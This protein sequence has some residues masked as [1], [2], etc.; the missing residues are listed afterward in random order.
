MATTTNPFNYLSALL[1]PAAF[2]GQNTANFWKTNPEAFMPT[3][4]GPVQPAVDPMAAFFQGQQGA[5][6]QQGENQLANL[7]AIGELQAQEQGRKD[8]NN[9]A[10][11]NQLRGPGGSVT[12]WSSGYF[13]PE[14]LANPQLEAAWAQTPEWAKQSS[15]LTP[16]G[17]KNAVAVSQVQNPTQ[18]PQQAN[19]N[20]SPITENGQ[21]VGNGVWNNAGSMVGFSNVGTA[22]ASPMLQNSMQQA[23]SPWANW[24]NLIG[25]SNQDL[26]NPAFKNLFAS[27]L[28]RR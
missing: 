13:K 5:V 9:Q 26:A 22:P 23:Q 10:L 11:Q 20:Y 2:A 15:L 24:T 8:A 16:Q 28:Q 19:A 18:M 27:L 25:Q 6:K 17:M 21:Q 1:N 7:R 3:T 14:Q 4:S 12:P